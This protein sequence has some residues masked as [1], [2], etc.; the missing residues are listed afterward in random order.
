MTVVPVPVH[1]RQL[2]GAPID[3]GTGQMLA[4]PFALDGVSFFRPPTEGMH[5]V[6]RHSGEGGRGMGGRGGEWMCE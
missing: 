1:G 4:R 2:N 3:A 5:V 6:I